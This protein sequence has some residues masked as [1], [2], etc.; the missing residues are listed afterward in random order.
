MG[1]D[2]ARRHLLVGVLLEDVPALQ[3]ELAA[4]NVGPRPVAARARPAR[5]GPANPPAVRTVPATAPGG[6]GGGGG[7]GGAV[8]GGGRG[9]GTCLIRRFQRFSTGGPRPP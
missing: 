5:L 6:G 1:A 7:G 4:W 8:G 3:D 9:R 2:V